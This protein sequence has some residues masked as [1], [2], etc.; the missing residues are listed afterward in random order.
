MIEV[1]SRNEVVKVFKKYKNLFGNIVSAGLLFLTVAV[2]TLLSNNK[3]ALA[4]SPNLITGTCGI[5]FNVNQ[6]GWEAYQYGEESTNMAIGTVDFNERKYGFKVSSVKP[7][8]HS[9]NVSEVFKNMSGTLSFE[10]FNSLTGVHECKGI[11]ANDASMIHHI[12]VVPVNSGNT[13]LITT[14][15]ESVYGATSAVASGVCQKI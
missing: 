7:F 12:S 11:D 15:T 1:R 9:S 8:G 14:Y 4:V 10:G 13:L 5:I 6:D 3:Q 2:V